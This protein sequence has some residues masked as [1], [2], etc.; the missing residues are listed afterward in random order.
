MN[1]T[2]AKP[3]KAKPRYILCLDERDPLAIAPDTQSQRGLFLLIKQ[4]C[5]VNRTAARALLDDGKMLIID[6]L[7]VV[8]EDT[9]PN[10]CNSIKQG[11]RSP[12]TSR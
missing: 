2:S 11:V 9:W 6:G 8:R 10:A 4:R 5:G 7:I 1:S 3:S 12:S